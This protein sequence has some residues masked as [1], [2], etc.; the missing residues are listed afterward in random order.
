MNLPYPTL[1]TLVGELVRAAACQVVEA[2]ARSG[3]RATKK[4]LFSLL[5]SLN[6]HLRYLAHLLWIHPSIHPSPRS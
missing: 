6:E 3:L 1:P 4:Q 5:E 2:V